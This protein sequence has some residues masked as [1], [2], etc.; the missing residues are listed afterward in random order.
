MSFWRDKLSNNEE[1]LDKN[2]GLPLSPNVDEL[3]DKGY[4]SFSDKSEILI[5][6]SIATEILNQLG[7][8][9]TKRME[10]IK[11]KNLFYL[12]TP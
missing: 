2:N 6:G 7:I 9:K 12:I 1:K 4:I 3:F 8:D 11:D 10:D 5:H